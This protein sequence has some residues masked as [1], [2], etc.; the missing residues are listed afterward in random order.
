MMRNRYS[1][2]HS[3]NGVHETN[4][5]SRRDFLKSTTAIVAGTALAGGLSIARGARA[6][7]DP[8]VKLALDSE[9]PSVPIELYTQAGLGKTKL[10]W[11]RSLDPGRYALRL[12]IATSTDCT[13]FIVR[14]D[15][16]EIAYHSG[17]YTHDGKAEAP[18]YRFGFIIAEAGLH[19]IEIDSTFTGGYPNHD[20]PLRIVDIGLEPRPLPLMVGASAPPAV[21]GEFQHGWGWQSCSDYQRLAGFVITGDYWKKRI[22]DESAKWGANYI[23]TFPHVASGSDFRAALKEGYFK[24]ADVFE[25]LQ[26]AR[27]MG[28]LID[29]HAHDDL[30]TPPTVEQLYAVIQTHMAKHYDVLALPASKRVDVFE[31]EQYGGPDRTH[32]ASKENFIKTDH[33]MWAYSPGAMI[34]SC[35]PAPGQTSN[36]LQWLHE[37]FHGPN[38][39]HFMM[40]A[41]G[42]L[43]GGYDDMD[44][45]SLLP[46]DLGFRNEYNWVY[47]GCQANSRPYTSNVWGGTSSIDWIAKQNWDFFRLHARAIRE[48]RIPLNGF[49]AWL[50]EDIFQLPEDMRESVYAISMDPCRA[51]LAYRLATTGR[52]GEHA[53]RDP[54]TRSREWAPSNTLR[55]HNGVLAADHSAFGDQRKLYWDS[56]NLGHFD[57]NAEAVELARSFFETVAGEREKPVAAHVFAP[58]KETSQGWKIRVPGGTYDLLVRASAADAAFRAELYLMSQYLG[59]VVGGAS[60]SAVRFPCFVSDDKEHSLELRLVDGD[61]LPQIALELLATRYEVKVLAAFGKV[62]DSSQEFAEKVDLEPIYKSLPKRCSAFV[63]DARSKMIPRFISGSGD[64]PRALDIYFDGESG[65]YLLAVR[66]RSAKPQQVNVTLN[67]HRFCTPEF[68][69]QVR[70][71]GKGVVPADWPAGIATDWLGRPGEKGLIHAFVA[72]PDWQTFQVP[73]V[74]FHNSGRPKHKIELSVPEGGAEVELDA[75]AFYIDPAERRIDRIGGHQSILEENMVRSF[76]GSVLD[77]K[78]RI[79]VTA[80]EPTLFLE[81][82]RKVKGGPIKLSYR[83]DCSAYTHLEFE[84][85]PQ[86]QQG[87]SA[88]MPRTVTMRDRT[89]LRP[90]LTMLFLHHEGLEGIRWSG[91]MIEL[92][93]VAAGEQRL[94]VAATIRDP[95]H[96]QLAEYLALETETVHLGPEGH[97]IDNKSGVNEVR[98]LRIGNPEPGPY[99]VQEKGWWRVRG[100]QPL[101]SSESAWDDYLRNYERWRYEGRQGAMPLPPYDSDLVRLAVAPGEEAHVQKYG[102]INGVVR[103]GWGSQKQMLLGDVEPGKCTVRVL[104]VTPY[105]YAPRIEFSESFTDARINGKPWAYHDGKNVFLPQKPDDYQVEVFKEGVKT[106]TITTTSA[107]VESAQYLDKTL[108]VKFVLPP[109]VFKLPEGLNYYLGL[110]FDKDVLAISEVKGG[111]IARTGPR[112]AVV[113]CDGDLVR[114]HFAGV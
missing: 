13:R 60:G 83:V 58:G 90:P 77:E 114:V 46:N 53:W 9:A 36:Y 85:K 38:Y 50:G 18:V 107:Q 11:R 3:T 89:G 67:S 73:V 80:E 1:L 74:C 44:A 101:K 43:S 45:I 34:A 59:S 76:G 14:V 102:Y 23:Q 98:L 100:A 88:E 42:G 113:K 70:R 56:E 96:G 110:E 16:R 109:Y 104:S 21:T 86:Q 31:T 82:D 24:D 41:A 54:S 2:P 15:H 68:T 64:H 19:E 111:E 7:G 65:S 81:I 8:P 78:R 99:F 40:C 30:F 49:L 95:A 52:N 84:G 105:V 39:A 28:M 72:G 61:S 112:G 29:E 62:D 25:C 37:D 20:R 63:S 33:V 87:V 22:V 17:Y 103:P 5:A 71:D 27:G 92:P 4:A 94:A 47:R 35:T 93:C 12:R 48:G 69:E 57:L 10:L 97:A 91:G 51:A 79:R 66:A 32:V 75:V 26:Y 55:I 106:P 108:I 6:A